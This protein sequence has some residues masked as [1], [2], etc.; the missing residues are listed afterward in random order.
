MTHEDAILTVREVAEYL[1]L[2][3]STV[4]KLAQAGRLPG[5]KIGGAWRFSRKG[6]DQWLER[7]EIRENRDDL[8]IKR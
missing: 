6:L 8:E 7:L 1:K 2:A 3:K 5:R 4:Y